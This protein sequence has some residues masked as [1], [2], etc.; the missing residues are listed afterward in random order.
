MHRRIV[1]VSWIAAF[2]LT[3][4]TD[5]PNEPSRPELPAAINAA[6]SGSQGQAG[7]SSLDLIEADYAAGAIDKQNVN[8]YREQA[9]SAPGKLPAKYRSSARA[10]DAT[11]SLVR[12]AQEWSSLSKATQKE[13]VDLRAD[14]LG[15]LSESIQTAHFVLHYTTG[16]NHSVPLQDADENNVPDFIDVAAQSLEQVWQR[17]VGQLGY[18][19]PLGTPAQKFHVYFKSLETYYG[20]AYPENVTLQTTSPVPLGT[21]SAYIVIENDFYGFPP[22]DEDV[23][24][25]EVIRSGAL[26]VTLAHEFMHAIQFNINVYASGWLMES[27]ATWAEDAVYDGLNDWHWYVPFFLS[28]PDL[29]LFSRYLYGAAFFQHWLSETYGVDIQRQIWMAAKTN[30]LADAIRL[31]AFGG[32]WEPFRNF[33]PAEYRLGI[34]D[35]TT[36]PT[37]IIPAPTND[38]RETHTSYPVSVDVGASTK[39]DA[40]GAPW[41][42]GANFIEFVPAGSGSLTLTFDGAD[43]FAWRAFAVATPKNGGAPTT[44]AITLNGSSAGSISLNGFGTRWAKVALVPTIAGTDGSAVPFSYGAT[45][46]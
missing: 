38:I 45:V 33:A 32:S 17:E 41:G 36:D 35:F 37:S 30:T 27:H 21:A 25:D 6:R 3:A 14:G 39:K 24:G 9:L 12:M 1:R 40:N 46:N 4:C 31:T 19:A 44:F 34:S 28:T 23:T 16:G 13:I 29:P 11:P 2:I 42:L 5:L 26:K 22:N 18:P 20:A 10:K 8:I 15:N 43:G 7:K